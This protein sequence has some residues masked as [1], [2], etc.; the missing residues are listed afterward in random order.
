MNVII[1]SILFGLTMLVFGALAFAGV[2]ASDMRDMEKLRAHKPE[3]ADLNAECGED[4]K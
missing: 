2:A 3:R 4:C 1:G